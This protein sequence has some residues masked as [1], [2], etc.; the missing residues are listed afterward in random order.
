MHQLSV[1]YECKK[2][3]HAPSNDDLFRIDLVVKVV[4]RAMVLHIHCDLHFRLAVKDG[5]RGANLHF[6]VV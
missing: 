5:K 3:V 1:P 4:H 6:A 2:E